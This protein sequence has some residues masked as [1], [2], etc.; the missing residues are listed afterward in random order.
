[1]PHLLFERS[2]TMI[3]STWW[4]RTSSKLTGKKSKNQVENLKIIS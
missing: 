4:L 3:I 1:M 2:L